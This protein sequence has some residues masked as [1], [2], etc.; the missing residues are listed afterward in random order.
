MTSKMVDYKVSPYELDEQC[1]VGNSSDLVDKLSSLKEEIRSC[2][3]DND[4]IMQAYKKQ[5]KVN[6][7]TFQSFGI[8]E[9]R[10]N[11]AYCRRSCSGHRSYRDDIIMDGRLLDTSDQRGDGYRYYSS[12][13][14]ERYHGHHCYHPYRRSDKGYFWMN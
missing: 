4:R 1:S 8:A 7:V 9:D 13:G 14:S 3:A 10:T 12:Y 2:N 11:G 6:V 5:E